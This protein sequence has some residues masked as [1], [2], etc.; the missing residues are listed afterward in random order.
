MFLSTLHLSYVAFTTPWT[1][2][3]S[4]QVCF[5]FLF[6]LS[7][8]RPNSVSSVFRVDIQPNG[9]RLATCGH[10]YEIKIWHLDS[11]L[12]ALGFN[13]CPSLYER[14]L[15]CPNVVPFLL[16]VTSTLDPASFLSQEGKTC[17]AHLISRFNLAKQ[18][19]DSSN[20]A[21]IQP[22]CNSKPPP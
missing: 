3:F 8:Y 16:A 15:A 11:T 7:H 10:C 17:Y 14:L 21:P 5:Y 4:T 1:H 9:I 18:Q 6:W 22:S 19:Q 13:A 2:G 12:T 20:G